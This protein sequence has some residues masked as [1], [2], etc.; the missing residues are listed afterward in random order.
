MKIYYLASIL[1][2]S[3]CLGAKSTSP[4]EG[5]RL[6]GVTESQLAA[7]NTDDNCW[8]QIDSDAY[9][10]TAYAPMHPSPGG[11]SSIFAQCS[12]DVTTELLCS[13]F[14]LSGFVASSLR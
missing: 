2:V 3:P 4:R 9:D 10:V 13:T 11:A 5:R 1:A 14:S 12:N 6:Q 7:A 8:L